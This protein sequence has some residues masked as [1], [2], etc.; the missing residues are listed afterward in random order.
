MI[1]ERV[2]S[3]V[4]FGLKA[5]KLYTVAGDK[6]KENA[7]LI[8]NLLSG[9]LE[10]DNPVE[11]FVVMNAAALMVV[12]GKARDEKHGVKLARE[13]IRS[14]SAMSALTDYRDAANAAIAQDAQD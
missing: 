2:L 4:T 6:P 11:N 1:L 9:Q 3:P 7:A 13:A 12:T 8:M 10:S 5:H 14:G